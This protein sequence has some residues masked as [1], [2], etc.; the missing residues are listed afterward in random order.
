MSGSKWTLGRRQTYAGLNASV[1]DD[2]GRAVLD[3]LGLSLRPSQITSGHHLLG[4]TIVELPTGEGKTIATVFPAC[5]FA[6]RGRKVWIATANDYL[7][8]RDA[9][10]MRPVYDQLGVGVVS[11]AATMSP[12]ERS[13]A[14]ESDVV[15]GTIRS[16]GFDF[17]RSQIASEDW[18]GDVL[19]VDEADSILIDEA[20]TPM[21][22]SSSGGSTEPERNGAEEACFR[23]AANVASQL[24]IDVDFVWLEDRGQTALTTIGRRSALD[25]VMPP[26]MRSLTTTEILHAVERSIQANQTLFRDVHYVVE[27][28]GICLV[29]EYTGRKSVD[30]TLGGGLHQ[31]IQAREGLT[32]TSSNCPIARITVMEFVDRFRHVCG[33]TATAWEDR[34]ELKSVYGCDVQRVESECPSKQV[35]STD[36]IFATADE[37]WKAIE[38][39]TVSMVSAGRAVLIGT[40]TIELSERLSEQ[41]RRAGIE[42]QLLTARN[43]EAEASIVAEAGRPGRVTI[44]TNLA[45][46]GTDIQLTDDVRRAGGL[47]VIVS[48]PHASSRIDRQLMGRGA[49]AGDPGT[50]CLF[51]SGE[52]EILAQAFGRDFSRRSAAS[53]TPASLARKLARAQ[54]MVARQHRIE[55]ASSNASQQ[56]LGEALRSLGMPPHTTPLPSN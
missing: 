42:H 46:R 18:R 35:R 12:S 50:A 26:Q 19:I 11:I 6:R 55:R 10:W 47:H 53:V 40:R 41:F 4:R 13:A 25:S 44:A 9:Q 34:Q 31:A 36:R 30:R 48:E 51:A 22:I 2:V 56:R 37:K 38:G 1:V 43:H 54:R 23:W 16:F 28:D 45:G 49:R 52:D 14:Y 32:I 17:L 27:G 29:D 8:H 5:A 39:E 33:L 20:R 7:A 3:K 24:R 15:Y 21:V